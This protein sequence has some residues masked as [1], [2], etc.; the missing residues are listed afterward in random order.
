MNIGIALIITICALLFGVGN[1]QS[2][3]SFSIF[4]QEKIISQIS[5]P[6]NSTS[7]QESSISLSRNELQHPLYLNVRGNG[8][9][10]VYVK[11]YVEDRLWKTIEGE[12]TP[13]ELTDLLKTGK[14]TFNIVGYYQPAMGSVTV[15]VKSKNNQSTLTSGGNGNLQQ[16]LT[17]NVF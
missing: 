4:S 11:I 6:G 3:M 5:Q 17:I 15:E 14:N 9:T 13:I 10:K 8:N 12:A 1:Y 7:Y 16:K 2:A